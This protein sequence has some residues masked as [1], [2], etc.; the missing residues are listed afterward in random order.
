MQLVSRRFCRYFSVWM[1]LALSLSSLTLLSTRVSA[2]S[3]TNVNVVG[4][5]VVGPAYKALEAAFQA[6]P[7][8]QNVTFTNSFGASD[9]ETNNVANGLSA[10][11]VNLSYQP[12]IATLVGAS[13]VPANWA[14]QELTI[15]HVNPALKGKKQQTVYSTPGI[16]TDS[17]VVFVVRPKNPLNI[18]SWSD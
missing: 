1:A 18:V 16:V 7:A 6:T 13:K 15:G 5:S 10:D 11:I 2:A 9:T 12:N 3:T 17:V 14:K 4:Y 8:G